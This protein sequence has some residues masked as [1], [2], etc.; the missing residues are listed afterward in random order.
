LN[1][2][3]M[4]TI[5]DGELIVESDKEYAVRPVDATGDDDVI[6]FN[7]LREAEMHVSMFGGEIVISRH[8]YTKWLPVMVIGE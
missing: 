2:G 8:F 3:A 7:D 5:I 4:T 1:G 6:E